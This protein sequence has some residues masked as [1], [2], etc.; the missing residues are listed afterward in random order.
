M[1]AEF[2]R[3]VD[4]VRNEIDIEFR[5]AVVVARSNYKAT[6]EFERS[7]DYQHVVNAFN[8]QIDERLN[9]LFEDFDRA[10]KQLP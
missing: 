3:N 10:C 8:R 2:R 1:E 6:E 7:V 9:V 4:A 5:K